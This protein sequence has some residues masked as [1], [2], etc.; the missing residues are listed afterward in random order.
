LQQA[1][2]SGAN[3]NHEGDHE[4]QRPERGQHEQLPRRDALACHQRGTMHEQQQQRGAQRAEHDE[5]LHE[6]LARQKI[7]S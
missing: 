1:G 3:L 2:S 6:R 5:R 7:D 4:R